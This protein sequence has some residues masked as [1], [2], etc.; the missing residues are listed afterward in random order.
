MDSYGKNNIN[1]HRNRD[2]LTNMLYTEQK[3]KVRE[4]MSNEIKETVIYLQK[5]PS[6]GERVRETE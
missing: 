2:I 5:H 1:V 4:W 6:K 3:K